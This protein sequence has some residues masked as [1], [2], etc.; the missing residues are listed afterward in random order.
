MTVD[1]GTTISVANDLGE[2]GRIYEMLTLFAR[3]SG[4]SDAARAALHLVA[5]ELFVNTVRYGYEEN[6]SDTIRI[7]AELKDGLPQLTIDDGAKFFDITKPP[8]QPDETVSLEDMQIGGLGLFLVHEY[9]Q[10]IA[11]S[12]HGDRN[13][14]R[15]VLKQAVEPGT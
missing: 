7:T 8:R 15:L 10:S 3:Q 2:L 13:R 14:T 5:E 12:R 4:V 11:Q 9:A 1:A 6:T